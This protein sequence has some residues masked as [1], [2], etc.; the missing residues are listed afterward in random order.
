MNL[1]CSNEKQLLFIKLFDA[2]KKYK[3]KIY[4][5]DLYYNMILTQYNFQH[6]LTNFELIIDYSS[7]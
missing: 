4:S 7:Y 1:K 3:P 2:I 5:H 6:Y